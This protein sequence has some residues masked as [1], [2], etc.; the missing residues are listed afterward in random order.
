MHLLRMFSA[1]ESSVAMIASL[2][3]TACCV[4]TYELLIAKQLA[5]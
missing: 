1:A 3:D 5:G 2:F 4:D